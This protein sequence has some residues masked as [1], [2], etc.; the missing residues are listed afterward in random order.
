MLHVI[1]QVRTTDTQWQWQ[2][3]VLREHFAVSVFNISIHYTSG[4]SV[5]RSTIQETTLYQLWVVLLICITTFTSSLVDW[6][7][8]CLLVLIPPCVYMVMAPESWIEKVCF[9]HYNNVAVIT[10][11]IHYVVSTSLDAAQTTSQR[12]VQSHHIAIRGTTFCTG[13]LFG[14]INYNDN[15]HVFTCTMSECITMHIYVLH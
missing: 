2:Y 14:G 8:L 10:S 6:F 7:V 5:N 13:L 12:V 1:L 11:I 15:N 9:R 3:R 4:D